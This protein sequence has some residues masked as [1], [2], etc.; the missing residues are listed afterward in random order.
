[1]KKCFAAMIALVFFASSAFCATGQSNTGASKPLEQ[2]SSEVKDVLTRKNVRYVFDMMLRLRAYGVTWQPE[3]CA[4]NDLAGKLNDEQLRMYAGMK[5]FDAIYAAT[6]MQRQAAVEAVRIM[7]EV[8]VKL[9]LRTYADLSGNLF[10]TM[11]KAAA[12]PDT[13]DIQ[14]LLDQLTTDFMGDVPALMASPQGADYLVDALCGF[15]AE[16]SYIVG[17]FFGLSKDLQKELRKG[18]LKQPDRKDWYV[19]I[20]QL[21]KVLGRSDATIEVDGQKVRKVAFVEHV[22]NI[23]EGDPATPQLTD[24]TAARWKQARAEF[25]AVRTAILTPSS[26]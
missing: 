17:Y 26:K 2:L 19:T 24:E 20:A 1:M 7:E 13:V 23:M 9:D 3:L 16:Y 12:A 15:T 5:L 18:Y 4:P 8:Q 6:F 25:K 14:E 10:T 22:V 11:K 21:F